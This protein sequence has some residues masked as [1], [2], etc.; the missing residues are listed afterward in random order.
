MTD[1]APV[2]ADLPVGA[3]S[4]DPPWVVDPTSL[5]WRIGLDR[6]RARTR[7]EVPELTRPRRIPPA[8]R[9]LATARHLVVPVAGCSVDLVTRPSGDCAV[10]TWG[11]DCLASTW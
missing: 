7:G 5:R 9:L 8:G 2:P 4:S 11:P 1:A 10:Q 6:V 3:F